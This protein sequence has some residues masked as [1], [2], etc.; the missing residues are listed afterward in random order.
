MRIRVRLVDYSTKHL[1]GYRP[2]AYDMTI[3]IEPGQGVLLGPVMPAPW[4]DDQP[5][6]MLDLRAAAYDM[7]YEACDNPECWCWQDPGP[8]RRT[9][10]THLARL[11]DD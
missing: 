9:A 4:P 2:V 1:P 3:E 6:W 7:T 5:K 10:P 11:P 8:E